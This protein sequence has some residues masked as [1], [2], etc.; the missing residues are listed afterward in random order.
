MDLPLRLGQQIQNHQRSHTKTCV[1]KEY[2][3]NINSIHMNRLTFTLGA[4]I[5]ITGMLLMMPN[6]SIHIAK[7]STCSGSGNWHG[8]TISSSSTTSG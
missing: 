5:M 6:G 3:R 1:T 4:V 7:A 8:N 2:A